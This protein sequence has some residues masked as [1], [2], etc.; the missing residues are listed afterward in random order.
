[1]PAETPLSQAALEVTYRVRAA[2]HPADC[3]TTQ[4]PEACTARCV[5]HALW[6]PSAPATL[7]RCAASCR[8][9]VLLAAPPAVLLNWRRRPAARRHSR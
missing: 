4:C 2:W 9:W 5:Q 6:P 1:M 7:A 8:L 3:L